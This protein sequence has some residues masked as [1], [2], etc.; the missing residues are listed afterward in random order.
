M[1]AEVM[2]FASFLLPIFFIAL[3]Y[4]KTAKLDWLRKFDVLTLF[5]P[6]FAYLVFPE[7]GFR[8]ELIVAYWVFVLFGT[9]LFVSKGWSYPQA[10]SLAFC[11]TYFGSF[12]W[13]LPTHIYT[14]LLHG[15][16]DGAFPLHLIYIFPMVFVYEKVKTNLPRAEIAK[17]LGYLFVYSI[18]VL[19][20]NWVWGADLWDIRNNPIETQMLLQAV[21]MLN[22]VVAVLGLFTI[23][24]VSSNRKNGG[25]HA[26]K[27]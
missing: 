15:G 16:V 24:R 10:L 13:E 3:Y 23:Y 6:I 4:V 8:I 22:R 2:R 14:I 9:R 7:L 26:E 25:K 1:I 5:I 19:S 20:M 21:W 17:L 27:L 12:L 11:L 18:C